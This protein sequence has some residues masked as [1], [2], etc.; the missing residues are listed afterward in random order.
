MI[1]KDNLN[2]K[3]ILKLQ[4]KQKAK[5]LLEN[6]VQKRTKIEKSSS[7]D[8]ESEEPSWIRSFCGDFG[9]EFFV[10]VDEAWIRD[11]FNLYGLDNKVEN[12]RDAIDIILNK[13]DVGDSM[14]GKEAE[15]LYGLI[16]ARF[17]LTAWGLEKMNRKY[18]TAVFGTCPRYFCNSC[19][20]LPMGLYDEKTGETVKFYCPSCNEIYE[21]EKGFC[22]DGAFF[23][24]SF[25]QMYLQAFP[26]VLVN[27]QRPQI[28]F[29]PRIFGFKIHSSSHDVIREDY[30][31]QLA[32]KRNEKQ[33]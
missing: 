27:V 29:T 4:N 23:G 21:S 5:T 19:A 11:E 14:E 18:E 17:I 10:E 12:Y 8:D 2:L 6:P 25:A 9:H 24:T 32:A 30:L 15:V 31:N 20:V 13:V 7:E 16:H 1:V 22:Y 3:R 28:K 33:G 26:K